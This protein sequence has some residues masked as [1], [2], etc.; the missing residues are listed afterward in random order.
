MRLYMTKQWK[1]DEIRKMLEVNDKAVLRGLVRIY[2]RQTEDEKRNQE[3]SYN[4][5]VGFNGSDAPIL[6]RIATYYLKHGYLSLKQ[7]ELVRKKMLKYSGQLA[8][9]ANELAQQPQH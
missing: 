5:K 6:T 9:I 2:E 4:N 3:T 8:N 7:I 1:K